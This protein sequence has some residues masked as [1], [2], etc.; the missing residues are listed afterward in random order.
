MPRAKFW[1]ANGLK[2]GNC[3]KNLLHEDFFVKVSE[4]QFYDINTIVC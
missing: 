4:T 3:G 2:S 1:E